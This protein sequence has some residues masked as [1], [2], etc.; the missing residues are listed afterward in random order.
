MFKPLQSYTTPAGIPVNATWEQVT[1]RNT[2]VIQLGEING[3]R[4]W[5]CQT[6][7]KGAKKPKVEWQVFEEECPVFSSRWFPSAKA[8][9]FEA[10]KP[11]YLAPVGR[12]SQ[13][14]P[15]NTWKGWF[16]QRVF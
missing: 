13:P 8:A 9:W 7:S 12:P 6:T 15:L 16:R 4:F 3:R 10:W 5:R 1:A 14:A 2:Q 11:D